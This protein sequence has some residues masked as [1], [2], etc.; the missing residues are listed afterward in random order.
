MTEAQL[1]AE[2][3]EL[4]EKN[5][6]LVTANHEFRMS[7]GFEYPDEERVRKIWMRIS[8]GKVNKASFPLIWGKFKERYNVKNGICECNS[9]DKAIAECLSVE[10]GVVVAWS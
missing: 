5:N 6:S 7:M 3:L 4:R 2:V 1:R 8:G 9:A 10:C